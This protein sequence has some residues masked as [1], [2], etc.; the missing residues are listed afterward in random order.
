MDIRIVGIDASLSCTGYAAADVSIEPANWS[1]HKDNLFEILTSKTPSAKALKSFK[2]CFIWEAE[3]IQEDKETK[4]TLAATRK[5]IREAK[6]LPT[7]KDLQIE[8]TLE[9]K[10]ITDQV[11][12]IMGKVVGEYDRDPQKTFIF[13]EDYSYHSPGSITQLAEM[14]GLLKVEM[15]KFTSKVTKADIDIQSMFYITANINTVKKVA[16][17]NGNANKEMVCEGLKRFDVNLDVKQDDAADA[18]G[19]CLAGFY[20]LYHIMNNFE[21]PKVK[22][23]KERKFYKSFIES[24]NTF[25][26]RIGSREELDHLLRIW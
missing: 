11:N 13:V 8:E 26:N 24:L 5:K 12:A 23:A 9:T 25:A 16:A 7:M 14:K 10:R 1:E 15:N 21:V 4:K 3:E 2:E 18:V 20:T 19:I 22:T 6:G 17:L